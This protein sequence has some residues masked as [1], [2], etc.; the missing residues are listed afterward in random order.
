MAGER[1]IDEQ[2]RGTY[3]FSDKERE[4]AKLDGSIN[5]MPGGGQT[6]RTKTMKPPMA[7]YIM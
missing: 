1:R 3:L 2:V 5:I 7:A 6:E 4:H